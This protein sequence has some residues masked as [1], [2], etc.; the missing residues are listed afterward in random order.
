MKLIKY[1]SIAICLLAARNA[2]ADALERTT[3]VKLSPSEQKAVI[4]T[5]DGKLKMVGVGDIVGDEN[6]IREISN[7]RITLERKSQAGVETIIV[8]LHNG[9]QKIQTISKTAEKKQPLA[10]SSVKAEK[11]R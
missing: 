7:D 11:V 2:L 3:F 6:K 9:K 1:I 10:N 8:T 4:K 5:S